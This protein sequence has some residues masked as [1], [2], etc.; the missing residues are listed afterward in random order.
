MS[1][2]IRMSASMEFFKRLYETQNPLSVF[3]RNKGMGWMNNQRL[4]KNHIISLALG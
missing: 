4:V 1:D 2:N 3:A